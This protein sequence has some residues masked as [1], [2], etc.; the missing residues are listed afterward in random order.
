MELETNQEN[1]AKEIE[2]LKQALSEV[3]CVLVDR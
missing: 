1:N 2:D 3:E